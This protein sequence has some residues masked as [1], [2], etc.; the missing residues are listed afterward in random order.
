MITQPLAHYS[1][2]VNDSPS[3]YCQIGE[4]DEDMLVDLYDSL[5]EIG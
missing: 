1:N 5:L 3:S 2:K 4:I